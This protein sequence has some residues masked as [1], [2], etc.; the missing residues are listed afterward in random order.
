VVKIEI[1]GSGV[2]FGYRA[3]AEF[4]WN[5]DRVE[6][7]A[8][9]IV[10]AA[11]VLF[12][13]VGAGAIVIVAAAHSAK[14]GLIAPVSIYAITLVA[15]FGV[16][17]AYNMWPLTDMKWMLRRAD[18]STVYIFIAGT[19][20]P[21]MAHNSFR[22]TVL[23]AGVWTAAAMGGL[24]KVMLPGR[25]DRLAIGLYLSLGWCG[26][27]AYGT[28]FASLPS[29]S[30]WLL[31]AGGALYSI[32]VIFYVWEDLRFQNAIWH[33]FVL[34]AAICHCAAVLSYATAAGP[35]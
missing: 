29:V 8:D 13:L 7:L 6:I 11:S 10:H 22:S 26:L 9:G 12:S 21:F 2:E 31:V 32:G 15:M 1:M 19:Y 28:V 4:T 33:L 16:S 18:H 27:A 5:Y 14:A 3:P 34:L 17:A 23:L 30:F 20:T 25:F 35:A 24:L